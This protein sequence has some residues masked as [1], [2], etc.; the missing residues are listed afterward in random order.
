VIG[1]RAGGH[2]WVGL[3]GVVWIQTVLV[4]PL[5]GAR[6]GDFAETAWADQVMQFFSLQDPSVRYA[7]AGAACLGICCGLLGSFILV[8]RLAL[9]GDALSHAVLPGVALGFLWN[10]TKDPIAIFIGATVAGLLGTVTLNL[11]RETTAIREDS[12]LG[13]VLAGF[14]GFGICL[15]TMIQNLPGGN[16]A[17]IDK[18]LFGQAAA[19]SSGDVYLMLGVTILT[20]LIVTVFYK[21]LLVSGFDPG[22]AGGAGLPVRALHY[23]VMLLL[24]FAVVVALQAVGVVLVSAML[25]TPAAAAY[26]LTDRFHR[27]LFLAAGFGLLAGFIGV[28]FSFLGNNL[29]TGP[30][31]VLGA[32]L[33]FCL[34][35]LAGPRHGLLPRWWKR[36][37]R[38]RSIQ[39]ENTLKSIYQVA[40][41]VGFSR[42]GVRVGE[43]SGRRNE[44]L[45]EAEQAVGRLVRDGLATI[46]RGD[47]LAQDAEVLLTP[48][49]WERARRIVRNHRLWELYLAN[50]AHY[51]VDH[52]HDDAEVIEHVLGE[53][54][55]R[56]LERRLDYPTRDPH[57]SEIPSR[58]T[59]VDKEPGKSV[60]QGT[61]RP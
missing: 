56:R 44:S 52:V 31:M 57:G 2:G 36:Y 54:T 7:L 51:E 59:G 33:V 50:Q 35:F 49:G 14:Y 12:A 48:A 1:S 11:I 28:F 29:P 41:S 24:A 25:I 47:G 9:V 40:E 61:F 45:V 27:M 10:L 58:V 8:R 43:L 4:S 38:N 22:F 17:G 39:I 55:V 23:L 3:L 19:L 13:M 6:I 34:A 16:K 42:D 5:H 20:V 30:F 53:E 26:L 37:R 60:A 32:T 21:E 18:Y 15:F 46:V